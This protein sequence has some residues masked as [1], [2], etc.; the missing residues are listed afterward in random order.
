MNT[1]S[2][3]YH[4]ARKHEEIKNDEQCITLEISLELVCLEKKKYTYSVPRYYVGVSGKGLTTSMN[5]RTRN[6]QKI[7]EGK[8][9]HY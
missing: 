5:I 1:R 4:N 2:C 3:G 8:G 9:C 6:S 7:K